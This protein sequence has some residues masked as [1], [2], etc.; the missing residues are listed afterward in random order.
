MVR[1]VGALVYPDHDTGTGDQ[2]RSSYTGVRAVLAVLYVPL[3]VVLFPLVPMVILLAWI[4]R[5]HGPNHD[6]N[7][8]P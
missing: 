3:A 6:P 5:Q 8:Y 4:F 1:Q 7:R 2:S